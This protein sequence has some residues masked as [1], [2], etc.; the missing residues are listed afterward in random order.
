MRINKLY[1]NIQPEELPEYQEYIE[2]HERTPDTDELE[3]I[4]K[5]FGITPV[6][7]NFFDKHVVFEDEATEHMKEEI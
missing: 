4:A 2:Q 1:E 6:E 3:A 7:D 5:V